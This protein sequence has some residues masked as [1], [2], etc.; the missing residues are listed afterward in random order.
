MR[1]Y[2]QWRR[3]SPIGNNGDWRCV[4]VDVTI[5]VGKRCELETKVFCRWAVVF[6]NV[7]NWTAGGSEVL[8]FV[9]CAAS[10]TR[11]GRIH[12]FSCQSIICP[13]RR[14]RS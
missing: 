6:E 1:I 11:S 8:H 13:D 10:S 2:R 4:T 3:N 12:F 5:F 7:T 14:G 9:H